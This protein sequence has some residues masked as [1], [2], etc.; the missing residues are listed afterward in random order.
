MKESRTRT[1]TL[2]AA[3]ATLGMV[4]SAA[5]CTGP[6]TKKAESSSKTTGP[7][8][9][10][11]DKTT[12]MPEASGDAGEA[13]AAAD[14]MT[15]AADAPPAKPTVDDTAADTPAP[16]PPAKPVA[17]GGAVAP[18]KPGAP[19]PPPVAPR[20]LRDAAP[21][22]PVEP[23]AT[24]EV[25]EPVAPPPVEPVEPVKPVEPVAETAPVAD[26][27]T[28]AD[29]LLADRLEELEL[30]RQKN[31][32]LVEDYL[33][34]ARTAQK[35]FDHE[36]T[37]EWASAAL[38][39]DHDNE[40]AGQ[41]LRTARS[42]MGDR[43]AEIE[44]I[45]TLMSRTKTVKREQAQFQAQRYWTAAQEAKA[46]G[47]FAA[48]EQNLELALAVINNDP[49]G[50]NW[51]SMPD[52]V[53]SELEDVRGMK[54]D[55][56]KTARARAA[57]E[58][59]RSVKEE[60]ARRR[61]SEVE[62]RNALFEAA[63]EAFDHE[64]YARA[65]TLLE[66]YLQLVPGDTNAQQLLAT[67]SRA[68]HE[69]ASDESLKM[70]R[71]RFR[72]WRLDMKETT[73]PY[74]KILNWPDQAHWDR[75]TE[76]R[77]D[78]GV[79]EG[80]SEDSPETAN[81]KNKLR[82]ERVSFQFQG[83]EFNDV[84][85]YIADTRQINIV[86][87]PQV[88]PDLEAVPITLTLQDV[89]VEEALKTLNRIAGGLT[90]VVRGGVVL[91]TKP[92]FA[93]E[94]PIVQV[95]SV[96]DLTVSLTNF[97]APNLQLLPAGAEEDE[98][99]PRFGAA[100]EGVTAFGGAEDL[101]GLIQNNVSNPDYWTE[102]GVSI[103]ASGEDKLVVVAE[104]GVQHAVTSFL[105]DLR[106]F[107]GLVV[108]IETRFL[109]VT[110]N[111][112]RD[113]GVDIRGIGGGTPGRLALLDDVT[114]GLD[115]KASLGF[116][117]SG[118]GLP[119]NAGGS[120]TSGAFY[121]NNSDGDYRARTENIFDQALGTNIT[122]IG[123]AV[124]QYTLTDDTDLSLILRAVEKSQEGRLLQAPSVSVFNTQRANIT[125]INQLTF[126][127]DFDVEVAQTAFIAD[128]IIGI[129]QD[130][131]VLDV[132]PTVS[133]DR[134]YITLQLK[135]TVA[136]LTR[137]IP[138]FTT[139]LGAFT[140]PVTIQIPELLVQ[141]AATTVRV[142]D[143]GTLLLGGLK[144]I[145]QKDLKSSTPFFSSIPFASFFFSRKGSSEEMDNLMVIVR[146]T[147]TDLQEQESQLRR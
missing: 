124:I 107:A 100:T 35:K 131:V 84:I 49:S 38:E 120:P 147:I 142:P 69:R 78:A 33:G 123:G 104:P 53:K 74:H 111:F 90:Y 68:K 134:K 141:S 44:T 138:T 121:N 8:I 21:T 41:L 31:A 66:D 62:K 50:I 83:A 45:S 11:G 1:L 112:L 5:S 28:S 89:T 80:P 75:I 81:T 97:I 126:I 48:A 67:A 42:A 73:V 82:G 14:D 25:E 130:G 77:K 19:L 106:A 88:A 13:T 86:V 46:D 55:A 108:T 65:E 7:A 51:G 94:A 37:A 26:A 29:K 72:E 136:N 132:Q 140:T 105:D 10:K 102:E 137:P 70:Q 117:N 96:G 52:S 24:V 101:I 92:E 2:A 146:A 129:I 6:A 58:A 32:I 118:P 98:D 87:D 113:V 144:N 16:P 119:A 47:D 139:S 9:A 64:Q 3:L 39:L 63:M 30:E 109:T 12:A 71:D 127:Q 43:D 95:H 76:L 56:E 40:E 18:P 54:A 116:D 114:N 145:S 143:G 99:S 4:V 128:P 22:K 91:V 36:A 110:D 135:P 125:L 60:E 79:I 61:L 115:D 122:N 23:T 133:N 59:Y 34:H 27:Q 85:R 103:A 17:E 15:A 57:R 93:R 20:G